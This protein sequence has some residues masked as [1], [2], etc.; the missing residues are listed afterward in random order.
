MPQG[1]GFKVGL[2]GFTTTATCDGC[3]KVI[4][5][6][7]GY[8]RVSFDAVGPLAS[9]YPHALILCGASCITEIKGV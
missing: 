7:A 3:N 9:T 2:M 6:S 5:P 8:L 1:M 4:E